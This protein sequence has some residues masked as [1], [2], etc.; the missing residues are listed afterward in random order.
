MAQVH[1]FQSLVLAVLI[2]VSGMGKVDQTSFHYAPGDFQPAW[3]QAPGA[4]VH[5]FQTGNC[6]AFKEIVAIAAV[7]EATRRV[8]VAGPE[9]SS[10]LNPHLHA[11]GDEFTHPIGGE[12]HPLLVALDLGGDA[13]RGHRRCQGCALAHNCDDRKGGWSVGANPR[14]SQGFRLPQSASATPLR[15]P[16]RSPSALVPPGAA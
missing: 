8:T 1:R 6:R 10:R 3:A 13:D 2:A 4:E 15:T 9:A 12:S 16:C 11:L 14:R 5:I 7:D